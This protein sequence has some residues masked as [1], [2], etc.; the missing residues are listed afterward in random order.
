MRIPIRDGLFEI[1]AGIVEFEQD[2]GVYSDLLLN[3]LRGLV[4]L[5]T[6][7]LHN[8]SHDSFQDDYYD[9]VA[10]QADIIQIMNSVTELKL[11]ITERTNQGVVLEHLDTVYDTAG[12]YKSRK[13]KSIK[14]SKELH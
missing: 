4:D 8:F 1:E 12:S 7:Q 10:C 5:L 2:E 13:V 11:D 3:K 14:L 9:I 6:Y